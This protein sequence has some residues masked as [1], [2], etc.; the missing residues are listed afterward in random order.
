[1][2]SRRRLTLMVGASTVT[3]IGSN[4]RS[5]YTVQTVEADNDKIWLRT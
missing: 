4:I 3:V 1:M 2:D 5:W